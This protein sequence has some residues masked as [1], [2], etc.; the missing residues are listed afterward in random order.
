MFIAAAIAQS[1]YNIQEQ[2]VT[3]ASEFVPR[4]VMHALAM[5]YVRILEAMHLL[6]IV[7][8]QETV[9]GGKLSG[10]K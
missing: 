6:Y 8:V 9:L 7:D 1:C 2:E 3:E 10:L 5:I 4:T